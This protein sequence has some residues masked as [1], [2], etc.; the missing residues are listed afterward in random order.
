MIHG[1]AHPVL[2]VQDVSFNYAT[3]AGKQCSALK[4]INFDLFPSETL[5]VIGRNGAGKS[6]L[7]RLLAGIVNPSSGSIVRRPEVNCGLLSLGVGFM[8][9]LTGADNVVMSLM[10]QGRKESEARRLLPEIQAFSELGDAFNQRVK[11]YSAGMRSRL[12]FSTALHSENEVLLVDEVLAVGDAG[13]RKKARIALSAKIAG[14]QT[15]VFVS[16]NEAS[17]GELCDRVLWIENA[18]VMQCGDTTEVLRAYAKT[19]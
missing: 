8:A 12:T 10:L 1:N 13:F 19:I 11:T 9:D 6:T 14:D 5:G 18:E 15:V 7:L 16:H 17:V 4:N 3:E 2:R